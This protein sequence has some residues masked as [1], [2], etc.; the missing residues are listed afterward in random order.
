[1]LPPLSTPCTYVGIGSRRTPEPYQVMMT[2]LASRLAEQ[3]HT[4]RSG[5]AP[6]ADA[7]FEAGCDAR[8]GA[9]EVYLPWRFFNGHLS[10]LFTPSQEAL[11][12]ACAFHPAWERCT[13]AARRLLGRNI[14]QLLGPALSR[15]AAFVLCWAPGPPG[16]E[17]GGT[18][19]TL[20]VARAHGIPCHNLADPATHRLWHTFCLGR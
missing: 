12:L 2:L 5:A 13:P 16:H 3:G 4:L 17:S 9:K 15:P 1:M 19:F 8:R 6:G 10:R 7:A 14:H 18:G 11:A 20:A